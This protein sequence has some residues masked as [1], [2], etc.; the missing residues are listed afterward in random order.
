MN[1]YC[2]C[3]NNKVFEDCCKPYI[4]GKEKPE[5]AELLMRS[6][7]TAFTKGKVDYL[8]KT[9]EPGSRPAKE[10]NK[11]LKWMNSVEWLGLVILN[12]EKGQ[13]KDSTGKVEFRAIYIEDGFTQAIHEK[14]IFVKHKGNW[15]YAN[16]EHY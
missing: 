16:G 1:E 6:R 7:Y 2:P 11:M 4:D 9:H 15:L 13:I 5:T 3:G 8:L 12:T 14:S 10:R